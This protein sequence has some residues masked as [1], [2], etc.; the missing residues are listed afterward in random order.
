MFSL[1]STPVT[2]TELGQKRSEQFAGVGADT[3]LRVLSPVIDRR[4]ESL[5]LQLCDCEPEFDKLIDLRAQIKEV[6]RIKKE[7]EAVRMVGKE[8]GAALEEIFSEKS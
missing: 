8:A 5:I 6:Y 7:L 2:P 4:M 3:L 1:R